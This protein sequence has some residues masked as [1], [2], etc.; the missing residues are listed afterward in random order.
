MHTPHWDML[1]HHRI[2]NYDVTL[3]NVSISI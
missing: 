3:L 2:T 1:P